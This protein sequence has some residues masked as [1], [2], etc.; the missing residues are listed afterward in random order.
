MNKQGNVE[1]LESHD[2]LLSDTEYLAKVRGDIQEGAIFVVRDVFSKGLCKSMVEYLTCLGRNSLPN[3]QPIELG[4]GNF[5]R[6]SRW[7]ER[8][9]VKA[10]FHQFVFYPW[11]QDI[12]DLF[13]VSKEVFKVK[14]LISGNSAERFLGRNGDEGCITRLAFQFYPKGIGG[15]N[16]HRDPVDFHQLTVPTLTLSK[17]GQDF[18]QGG[19]FVDTDCGKR[20]WTDE[21]SEVGDVVY[22]NAQMAHG[23]EIIDEGSQED[24]LSFQ[25]RWMLLFAINKL[26]NS[27]N[28]GDSQDLGT[29]A[30]G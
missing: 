24:W 9:H 13:E 2:R 20:I 10:C 1:Y 6:I 27:T 5:H 14:N 12:F 18:S 11:N 26:S 7:D 3:Y 29:S 22:F 15:M 4:T 23:V 17:K 28:V 25:G 19:A 21:I 30:N 16:L 8:S